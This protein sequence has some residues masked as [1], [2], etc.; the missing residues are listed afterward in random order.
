VK[1]GRRRILPATPLGRL[2][3]KME[4]AKANIRAKVEH[5][6]HIVKNLFR[7]RRPTIAIWQR[8]WLSFDAVRH[9]QLEDDQKRLMALYTQGAS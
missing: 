5:P 3:K 8:P 6:F 4:H 9:G 1:P 7:H 2:L